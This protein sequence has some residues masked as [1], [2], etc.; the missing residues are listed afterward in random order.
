[1]RTLS[2]ESGGRSEA[3]YSQTAAALKIRPVTVAELRRDLAFRGNHTSIEARKVKSTME[4]CV[5]DLHASVH[6][7]VQPSCLTDSGS[8]LIP[9][10]QLH[11]HGL[12]A[13]INRLLNHTREVFIAAENLDEIGHFW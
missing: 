4:A 3:Y 9:R 12:R 8:F 10:A 2:H 6:N 11:P 1:M 5:L 13:Q 7:H